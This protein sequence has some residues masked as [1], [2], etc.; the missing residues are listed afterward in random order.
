MKE[1]DANE[2]GDQGIEGGKCDDGGGI[3]LFEGREKGEKS[4]KRKEAAQCR[5]A[6]SRK[7]PLYFELFYHEDDDRERQHAGSLKK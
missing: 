7:I 1:G 6:E 3:S 4:D 5:P 2:N